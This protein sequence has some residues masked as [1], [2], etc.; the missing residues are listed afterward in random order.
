M[1][2]HAMK[3]VACADKEDKA[4]AWSTPSPDRLPIRKGPCASCRRSPAETVQDDRILAE[5]VT[6]TCYRTARSYD[7]LPQLQIVTVN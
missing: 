7:P 1:A 2:D 4:A 6:L 5:R 3:I